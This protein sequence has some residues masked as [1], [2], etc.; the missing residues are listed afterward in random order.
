[1]PDAD[2]VAGVQLD[3]H[4]IGIGGFTSGQD[5]PG[6]ISTGGVQGDLAPDRSLI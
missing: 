3:D 6:K 1:V 2:V 5:Q 4:V